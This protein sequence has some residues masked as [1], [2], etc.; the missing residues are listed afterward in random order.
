MET[1]GLEK[2]VNYGVLGAVVC[3]MFWF[4]CT[5][6]FPMFTEVVNCLNKAITALDEHLAYMRKQNGKG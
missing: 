5:K 1:A 6:L 3:F 2:L 4:G